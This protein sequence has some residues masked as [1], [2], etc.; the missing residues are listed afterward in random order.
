MENNIVW[1]CVGG[2]NEQQINF[3][4]LSLSRARS[5][6]LSVTL[7]WCELCAKKNEMKIDAM[8]A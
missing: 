7:Y 6:S 5:L 8:I 2:W 4:A 3:L 1:L